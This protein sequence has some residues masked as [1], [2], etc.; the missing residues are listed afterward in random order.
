[1]DKSGKRL[2][3]GALA[4]LRI[5]GII[6]GG[7][8]YA[9][10]YFVDNVAGSADGDGLS[11]DTAMN[12]IA[13]AVTAWNTYQ[14][15]QT[16]IEVRGAI[17]IRGTAT[18]YAG[19]TALPSYCDMI[20][21]GA[22]PL[23][24]GTGIARIGSDTAAEDGVLAAS[25][26]IR[27]TNFYNLQFQAGSAKSC[28]TIQNIFRC[29]F[30]DCAF[31]VNGVATSCTTG[32]LAEKASGVTWENCHWGTA[33]NVEPT[34]GLDIS[35]SHFHH[36]KI[37]DCEITGLTAAFRLAS[38]TT[39]GYGSILKNNFIGSH[40]GT[41]LIGVDDNAT[42]GQVM[43]CGNFVA[44]T[45]QGTLYNNHTARWIG[46]FAANGFSTVTNS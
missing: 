42:V 33:S 32:F 18:A 19:L 6:T 46:N 40:Y 36:C 9:R 29:K 39:S 31:M 34:V 22:S 41:C 30:I 11:W 24:N 2:T 3:I 12:S 44:A 8:Q 45:A 26:T 35:G 5:L 37:V 1:M 4:E 23:G 27:G 28:F 7:V 38:G 16:N 43:Y 17:Y 21:V 10:Q 25:S 13:L 14:A 20:G 15:A